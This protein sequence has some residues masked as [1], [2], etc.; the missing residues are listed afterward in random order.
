MEASDFTGAFQ[1]PKLNN[2]LGYKAPAQ[3]FPVWWDDW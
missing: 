1:S 3:E 2:L